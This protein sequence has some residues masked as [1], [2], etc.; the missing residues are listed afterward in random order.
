MKLLTNI[1]F[2]IILFLNIS[3]KDVFS[4]GPTRQKI[5]ESITINAK[6]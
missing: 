3:T 1:L 6:P 5:K 2:F 4:H